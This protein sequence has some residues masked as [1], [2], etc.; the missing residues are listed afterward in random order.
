MLK[1]LVVKIV[2]GDGEARAVWFSR[3]ASWL[4]PLSLYL[5]T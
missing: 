5:I 3:H 2:R 1:F 4:T